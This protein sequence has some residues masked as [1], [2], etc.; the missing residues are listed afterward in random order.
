MNACLQATSVIATI[1]G[2][3]K[4][5]KPKTIPRNNKK[6]FEQQPFNYKQ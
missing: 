6:S 3:H 2:E 1:N 5:Y 4:P